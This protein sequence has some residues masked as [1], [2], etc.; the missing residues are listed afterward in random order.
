[1]ADQYLPMSVQADPPYKTG[2]SRVADNYHL[3]MGQ[4]IRRALDKTYGAEIAREIALWQAEN[5]PSEE[6]EDCPTSN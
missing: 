5:N 4:L 3:N 1:M 2:V 6:M